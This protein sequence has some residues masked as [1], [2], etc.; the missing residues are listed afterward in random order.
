MV[1]YSTLI[2]GHENAYESINSA[3]LVNED[4]YDSVEA[5]MKSKE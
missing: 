4:K 2:K 5:L 1:V 3:V